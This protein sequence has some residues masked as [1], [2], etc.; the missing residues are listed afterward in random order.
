[1]Q[2]KAEQRGLLIPHHIAFFIAEHIY[3]N[4]RQLEGALN[5]L[6]ACC[7]WMGVEITEEMVK[8]NLAEMLCAHPNKKISVENILTCVSSLFDVKLS[9][10]RGQSRSKSIALAR[11]V[12]MYL[13][14]ELIHDSLTRIASAFGG[15]AHSTL[16]HAWKKISGL[17]TKD[18]GLRRQID[19]AKHDLARDS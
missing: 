3:N 18:D 11:Q 7:R 13:S 12:A 14:R 19:I 1:L 4:V 17:L 15:K 16:L 8:K 9:D 5:R 10:L 6:N 2:H